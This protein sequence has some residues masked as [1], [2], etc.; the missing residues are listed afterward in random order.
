MALTTIALLACL[1]LGLG[2]W[3]WDQVFERE[4]R[5]LADVQRDE[6]GSDE[7]RETHMVATAPQRDRAPRA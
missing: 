3:I 7:S 4:S 1:T 5:R 6:E 2:L